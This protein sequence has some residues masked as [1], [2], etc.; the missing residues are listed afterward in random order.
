MSVRHRMT[1]SRPR[2]VVEMVLTFWL[3][4]F[5]RVRATE[6]PQGGGLRV[7]PPNDPVLAGTAG[8]SDL[9]MSPDLL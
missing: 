9:E 8:C 3:R 7:A 4:P 5:L 1:P 2:T 6:C